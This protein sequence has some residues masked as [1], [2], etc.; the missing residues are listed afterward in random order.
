MVTQLSLKH[1]FQ[2][3][4]VS[5]RVR[6]VYLWAG[7]ATIA[8][9]RAKFPDHGI[10]LA[11]HREAYS[12]RSARELARTGLNLALLSMNWGFPPEEERAHW[13]DFEAA[14]RVFNDAGISVIGY[15]QASN[16]L[17]RG[18]YAER[19]WYA[20]DPVGR[21]ISYFRDRLMTCWLAEEWTNEV[22]NHAERAVAGGAQGVFFDNLWLGATPW[23]IGG[24]VGGFAGCACPRCRVRFRHDMGQ[25]LPARITL[26]R[27]AQD[28]LEWRAAVVTQRLAEWSERVRSCHPDAVVLANNCDVL[29]RDTRSLFGLDPIQLAPYQDALLLEN[30]AVPRFD[31]ARR[32]LVTNALTLKALHALVP[33]RPVLAVTYEHGIGLDGP[34]N[35]RRLRRTIAET[36][37]IGAASLLKGSEYLDSAGDF[38]VITAPALDQARQEAGQMLR[39]LADH[40]HLYEDAIRDPA[41]GV[42]LDADALQANWGRVAPPTFAAALALQFCGIPYNFVRA[43]RLQDDGSAFPIIV[44]PG[45][46]QPRLALNWVDWGALD[47]P[48][49]AP[50]LTDTA[51]LR[52][53]ADP[54]MS[55]LSRHYFKRA[56]VRRAI[57]R[58]GLTRWFLQSPFFRI[59]RQ[60]RLLVAQLPAGSSVVS[61]PEPVLVERTRRTDGTQLLHLVNYGATT[62]R[63]VVEGFPRAGIVHSPDPGLLYSLEGGRLQLDL[64]I[65]AVIEIPPL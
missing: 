48:G 15:A 59:P 23:T 2:Q 46:T 20:L 30:V 32:L 12:E 42:L 31:A 43:D 53:A 5:S 22:G 16:C 9:Q 3:S 52:A 33:E 10:D 47:V 35:P 44:P 60:A 65:Y 17:A 58:T 25:E 1:A 64:D 19:E 55:A 13:R 21:R 27:A 54:V 41:V 49:R 26:D 4:G 7:E 8:L 28:Y 18:S 45:I 61:A 56:G 37:A 50:T 62:N 39:W 40:A 6:G 14:V 51:F 29:L 34:P 57:D 24:S 63:M 36:A 11:A 38:T